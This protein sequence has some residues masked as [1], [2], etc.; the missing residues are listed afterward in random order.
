[1]EMGGGGSTRLLMGQYGC[2]WVE[3]IVGGSPQSCRGIWVVS[4]QNDVKE[5]KI[6]TF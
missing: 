6:L 5:L 3:T 2:N 1:V 4:S